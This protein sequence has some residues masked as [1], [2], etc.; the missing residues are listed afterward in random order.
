[1][2]LGESIEIL[3]EHKIDPIDYNDTMSDVYTHLLAKGYGG[4]VRILMILI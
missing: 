4:R 2:Y 3:E 1:M